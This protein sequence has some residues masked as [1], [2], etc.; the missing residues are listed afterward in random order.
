MDLLFLFTLLSDGEYKETEGDFIS[1]I[2]VVWWRVSE[3]RWIFYFYLHCCLFESIMRQSE[4][5]FLL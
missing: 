2:A 3:D 5:L 4:I 1:I